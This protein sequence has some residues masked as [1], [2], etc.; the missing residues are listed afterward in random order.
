M[1]NKKSDIYLSLSDSL[2]ET[3]IIKSKKIMCF[4][5]ITELIFSFLTVLTNIFLMIFMH[6]LNIFLYYFMIYTGVFLIITW[7]LYGL[8]SFFYK[9][10][11]IW[12]KMFS[13]STL[14]L[15]ILT[16]FIFANSNITFLSFLYF[17]PIIVSCP[18]DKINRVCVFIITILMSFV[19][20]IFQYKYISQSAVLPVL[21]I[22]IFTII[23]TYLLCHYYLETFINIKNLNNELENNFDSISICN[24]EKNDDK[25]IESNLESNN[26]N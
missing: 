6:T 2:I 11:G 13:T 22:S 17:I 16:L 14:Y 19:Y 3:F 24:S 26:Y 21:C 23:V 15:L 8:Y 4:L 5:L 25:K 10:I 12:A 20:A 18:F 7:G 9:K 1:K